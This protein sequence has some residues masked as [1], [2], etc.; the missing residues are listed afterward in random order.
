MIMKRW[1]KGPLKAVWNKLAIIRRPIRARVD[2]FLRESIVVPV[3]Q[4]T[5]GPDRISNL[6]LHSHAITQ[7]VE[8][9]QHDLNL[10]LNDLVREVTRL[11]IQLEAIQERIEEQAMVEEIGSRRMAG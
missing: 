2:R 10:T 6:E 11:Q 3:V 8:L 7:R 1:I 5:T 9:I 4:G